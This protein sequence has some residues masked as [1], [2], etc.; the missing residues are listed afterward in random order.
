MKSQKTPPHSLHAPLPLR[1]T[2]APHTVGAKAARVR[3]QG[4]QHSKKQI[5]ADVVSEYLIG[6]SDMAMIYVSLDPYGTAFMEEINLRKFD[7]N[8]H[9]TAGLCFF[10]K[11][12]QIL[13][14][15]VA[16]SISGAQIPWWGTHIWGAWL[17][18]I[19]GTTVASILVAKAVLARL[20]LSNSNQSTLLFSH[21]EITP[22]ISHHGLPTISKSDFSQFTHDQLNN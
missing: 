6:T 7:I 11:N 18:E 21:P 8:T 15:S 17:I 12:N 19:D 16:P 10:E 4:D 20:S 14:A 2:D 1:I 5:E 22:D 3:S 9:R 13:L